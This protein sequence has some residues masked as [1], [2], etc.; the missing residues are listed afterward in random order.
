MLTPLQH[1]DQEY[2]YGII[3]LLSLTGTMESEI[4][5]L[6]QRLAKVDT[7]LIT[8]EAALEQQPDNQ[9]LLQRVVDLQQEKARLQQEKVILLQRAGG[10]R[11]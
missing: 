3:P 11:C 4:S 9:L 8:A 1:Y 5:A 7:T 2:P 10:C 6:A